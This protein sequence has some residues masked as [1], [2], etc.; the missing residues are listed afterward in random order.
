LAVDEEF[1]LDTAATDE[2]DLGWFR[3]NIF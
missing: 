2:Y 3:I 1:K